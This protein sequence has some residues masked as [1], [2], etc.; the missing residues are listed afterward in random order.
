VWH[1]DYSPF[2]L[3]DIQTQQITLNLRL[4]GQYEDQ[5]SGTYY[6]YQRDYDPNTGR[7][8][9]SDPIG[10]KGGMNTYAYV[11]GNPLGAIDPLGL[12]QTPPPGT[13]L[14]EALVR[15]GAIAASDGP[16]PYYADVAAIAYLGGFAL[17]MGVDLLLNDSYADVVE[18]SDFNF[19]VSEIQLYKPSYTY[20]TPTIWTPNWEDY[21]DL[22]DELYDTQ[23][24]YLETAENSIC[25]PDYAPYSEELLDRARRGIEFTSGIDDILNQNDNLIDQ[26]LE[27]VYEDYRAEGGDLTFEDWVA[28]GMP[29]ARDWSSYLRNNATTTER[30]GWIDSSTI[31][32]TQDSI[33]SSFRD[34]STVDDLISGLRNGTIDPSTIPS[35][36]IFEV[37]GQLFTLDN[38][39]LYAF[40]QAGIPISTQPATSSEIQNESYKF[41]TNNG[42]ISIRV[43]RRR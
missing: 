35:I 4:P 20:D 24:G 37:D 25:A 23:L 17:A 15:A 1:A 36:R 5:E 30:N 10:L 22:L 2:G 14:Y 34:G 11:G 38:R 6:N 31:R 28:Q 26:Q 12:F 16:E 40:Q 32:F 42:G 3:I 7:Y 21:F 19:I 41:T 8:L 18:Q 33:S 9:T 29:E 43:R 13:P 39:R 27:L